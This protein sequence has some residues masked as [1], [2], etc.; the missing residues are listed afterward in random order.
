MWGSTFADLAKQA[1]EAAE[2]ASALSVSETLRDSNG[3]GA[4]YLIFTHT[5]P[6]ILI[7]L[8]FCF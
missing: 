7:D 3:S 4:R 1:Q 8:F 6:A 2:K 5:M